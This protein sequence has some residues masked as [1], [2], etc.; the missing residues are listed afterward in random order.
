MKPVKSIL[1]FKGYSVLEAQFISR[2]Q[3]T[4]KNKFELNPSFSQE[5]HK[6]GEHTYSLILGIVIG[7]NEEDAIDEGDIPFYVSVRLQGFFELDNEEQAQPL[8]Q[9]NATSILYPYLRSTVTILTSLSNIN[10]VILPTIN[11]A[12][13]FQNSREKEE[14]PDHD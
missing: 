14:L 9:M 3:D 6:V 1:Q 13:M 4:G 7:N 10:P 8:M 5:I 2:L 11:L 12:Q